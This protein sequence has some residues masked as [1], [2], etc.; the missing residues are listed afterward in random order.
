MPEAVIP[1]VALRVSASGKRPDVR[2]WRFAD[3]GD[4]GP[5]GTKETLADLGLDDRLGLGAAVMSDLD[6]ELFRRA[7]E[8]LE[9]AHVVRAA[10][11]RY[12]LLEEALRLYR[13][14][15]GFD[16]RATPRIDDPDAA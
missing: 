12:L 14:A 7:V 15:R 4:V 11:E 5:A 1:P 13:L 2:F 16:T 10:S 8:A 9:K 3:L 6:P